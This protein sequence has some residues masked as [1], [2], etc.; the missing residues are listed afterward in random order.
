MQNLMNRR[1]LLT[2]YP[3]AMPTPDNWTMDTQPVPDP[4]A[5]QILVKAK[6]AFCRSIHARTYE[7]CDQL[8][9]G[10]RHW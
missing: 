8:Y 1:W 10:C 7:S 4:G 6:V 9:K 5:G 2:G 3:A